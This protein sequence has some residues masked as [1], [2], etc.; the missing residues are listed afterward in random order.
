LFSTVDTHNHQ[1]SST[2]K[3]VLSGGL[4]RNS[5]ELR[6]HGQQ[7]GGILRKARQAEH[8]KCRHEEMQP[9]RVHQA[10]VIWYSR[11][12]EE[13]VLREALQAGNG[14][15]RHQEVRPRRVHQ[16]AVV[17]CSGQQ[18]G[19]VLLKPRGERHGRSQ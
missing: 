18:E 10:T 4:L 11:Q 13:G 5:G 19:G 3:T 2:G 14:P 15:C 6:K 9:S 1:T 16:T 12:P 17:W 8:A 7:E